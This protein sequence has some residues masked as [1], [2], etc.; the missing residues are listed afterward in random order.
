MKIKQLNITLLMALVCLTWATVSDAQEFG[1]TVELETPTEDVSPESNRAP[2]AQFT[3]PTDQ[4][5][6]QDSQT[7]LIN[8]KYA[9]WEA[10]SEDRDGKRIADEL[11]ANWIMVDDN[12]RFQGEVTPGRNAEIANM[13]VYLMNL[14]RLVKQTAVDDQ[15]RFE[16][17]NV[18]QGAYSLI[19]WGEKGFFAFGLNIL[20]NNPDVSEGIQRSIQV[21]A[22]QNQTTINTDWIRHFASGVNFR[23]FGRYESGEGQD[24]PQELYGFRGLV[25]NKVDSSPATSISSHTVSKTADG[26]LIGRVHQLNSISGRPVDVR[27]TR[28][29]LLEAD[30]VVAA[31]STDNYGVF[32]FQ[33]VPDG[34]YGVVAAGV[35]GLGLIAI[36]VGSSDSAIGADGEF[37]G[38]ESDIIDFTMVSSETVG[39]LNHQ[40]EKV[41]Y[42][43]A[44]LAPRPPKP[45][46]PVYPEYFGGGCQT[47]GNQPG[48]CNHCQQEYLKSFCRSRGLSFQQWQMYCQRPGQ[49]TP[50]RSLGESLGDGSLIS[51]AARELQRGVQ[52]I[53]DTFERAFYP[54]E[55]GNGAQQQFQP[56]FQQQQFQQQ[57]F[58]PQ[59]QQQQFQPQFQQPRGF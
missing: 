11:R 38:T 32:E 43:R 33:Q 20:A 1:S 31:T 39:W 35:D 37:V 5:R 22:F 48:G 4:A 42:R 14:G 52:K 15:G 45:A 47:C 25:T 55:F 49:A 51:K 46:P 2:E 53:D 27:T 59:F 28:V 40:A 16:F 17:N 9:G 50:V 18:R 44:L 13:N 54:S 29:L 34:S 30:S 56:Q 3:P 26:R 7:I 41:S 57:Q 24:D 12:G 23:V 6:S 8:S 19:G 36:N 10:A 21:T 58:Q